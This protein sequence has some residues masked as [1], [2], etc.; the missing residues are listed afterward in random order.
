MAARSSWQVP[1]SVGILIP[2]ALSFVLYGIV[3]IIEGFAT[4]GGSGSP[5]NVHSGSIAVLGPN[6]WA[7]VGAVAGGGA[8]NVWETK[9]TG[10]PANLY[11]RSV[12]PNSTTNPQDVP[13]TGLRENWRLTLEYRKSDN[14][15]AADSNATLQICSHLSADQSACDITGPLNGNAENAVYVMGIPSTNPTG[16]NPNG[17]VFRGENLDRPMKDQTKPV[18]QS[19]PDDQTNPVRLLYERNDPGTSADRTTTSHEPVTNH[20][21]D[22]I[23]ESGSKRKVYRCVDSACDIEIRIHRKYWVCF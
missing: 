2:I 11:L 20:I 13:L 12:D 6:T 9:L 8:A 18:D 4:G 7:P 19:K 1:L 3:Q 21:F 16:P 23:F 22:V 5:V 15:Q 17:G 14:Y 10:K